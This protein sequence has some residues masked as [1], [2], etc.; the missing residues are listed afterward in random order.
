MMAN[1]VKILD[2]MESERREKSWI[3]GRYGAKKGSSGSSA[4]SGMNF[5]R[6]T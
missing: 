6:L 1:K 4:N 5:A 2:A 3:S